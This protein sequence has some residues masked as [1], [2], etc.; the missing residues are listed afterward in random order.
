MSQ[1][2]ETNDGLKFNCITN[3]K[4]K[5]FI[6]EC[7]VCSE[8]LQLTSDMLDG[9]EPTTHESLIYPAS[10]CKFAA[11]CIKRTKR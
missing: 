5:L 10:Y 6:L 4:T 3:G 9:L 1:I 8:N 11:L 2:V 7:P